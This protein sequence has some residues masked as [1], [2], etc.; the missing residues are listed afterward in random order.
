MSDT[1]IRKLRARV[2]HVEEFCADHYMQFNAALSELERMKGHKIDVGRP[3][4]DFGKEAMTKAMKKAM[5]CRVVAH[6]IDTTLKLPSS[7]KDLN[8]RNFQGKRARASSRVRFEEMT[9]AMKKAMKR[10]VVAHKIDTTLKSPSAYPLTVNRDGKIVRKDA[11]EA[12]KRYYYKGN[13]KAQ[14]WNNA[15]LKARKDLNITGFV[16]VGG[17]TVAG[18]ALLART[19]AIYSS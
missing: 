10:S 2:K 6:E 19:R 8:A 18:K 15:F 4:V 1:A 14:S 11:S 7:Y 16:P 3:T 12:G 13:M 9:K 17:K 5:K